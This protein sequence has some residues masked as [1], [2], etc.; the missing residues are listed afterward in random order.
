MNLLLLE[1]VD[2]AASL[3]LASPVAGDGIVFDPF[4]AFVLKTIVA[5]GAENAAGHLADHL[6]ARHLPLFDHGQ[7]ISGDNI[8]LRLEDEV[9][10][11]TREF[12]PR[13]VQVGLIA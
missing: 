9:A 12:L 4:A 2:G 7:I 1:G 13:F 8:R 3:A 5:V 10:R 6:R 11:F